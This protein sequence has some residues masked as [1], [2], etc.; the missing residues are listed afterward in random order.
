[1]IFWAK[2]SRDSD[3]P[4][5]MHPLICHMID[6]AMVAR[7]LWQD[8]IPP[9][10]RHRLA[11]DFRLDE[12][13]VGSWIAFWAGL[14]DIGKASPAFQSRNSSFVGQLE[15]E[16]FR[17]RTQHALVTPHGTM[18]ALVLQRLLSSTRFGLSRDLARRVA[19]IVGGHHG[20]F[21]R[22]SDLDRISIDASGE[23]S[24][25]DARVSLVEELATLLAIPSNAAPQYLDNATAMWLAGFVSVADWIG[26]STD[27]F[28]HHFVGRPWP[29]QAIDAT[30]YAA[31]A[32]AKTGRA[33]AALGWNAWPH[34]VEQRSFEALFPHIQQQ[35]SLQ[36]AIVDLAAG[37]R[38]D[39]AAQP[40]L[41]IIEAP[42]G[43]GKTE[44]AMYLADHFAANNGQLGCYFALPTQATS[45]QMF[46][47]VRQFLAGRY[48][49]DLV[50]LQLLHGHAS[51]SAE[52]EKLKQSGA[53]LF[54]PT[55]VAH[56]EDGGGTAGVAAA[57]W[58][59]YR[60]RGLLAPFGVGTVDQALM[61]ALQTKHMFVR[62][63]GLAGKTVIIDEVHA[64]DAYMSTL[65]E[66]LL[67]WLAA[68]GTSVILLSATLPRRRR[69]AL[70][71][72]YDKGRIPA[73][74]S[75]TESAA[76]PVA[77]QYV[78]YPRVTWSSSVGVTVTHVST[79]ARSRKTVEV[80]WI[81]GSLPAAANAHFALAE[82]LS[83]ALAHGGCA[84]VI[85]NTVNRAQQMY[86]ALEPYFLGGIGTDNPELD[87]VHARFP[88]EER[89][90]REKRIVRRFGK[91]QQEGDAVTTPQRNPH[92]PYRAV[93][94]ATQ[95]IEQSLDLD[96]DLLVT[97]IA[98]IDLVLQRSGRLHRHAE[99]EPR[100]AALQR[101]VLWVCNPVVE[102]DGVPKFDDGTAA[103]YDRHILLRSWL[104][105]RQ[106]A[107]LAVP[108]QVELLIEAVYDDS[109]QPDGVSEAV[110]RVW[111]ETWKDLKKTKQR[112]EYQ[113]ARVCVPSPSKHDDILEHPSLALEEDQP[114]IH[115]SLQA[116]T[117][118]SGPSVA[119]VLLNPSER[120]AAQNGSQP[121]P[122]HQVE[123]LL[124]KSLTISHR[125]LVPVLLEEPVPK[126]WQRSP[127]LRHHRALTLDAQGQALLG[128]YQVHLDP[129]IGVVITNMKNGN[130][131][132]AEL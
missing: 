2:L 21:P 39:E 34:G 120:D 62:L 76:I 91:E 7:A 87:I 77:E 38:N 124:H 127:L 8:V 108:D 86:R 79:S 17:C 131:A 54:Q 96:F 65:L 9:V 55:D 28:P 118:L 106:H 114:E 95:V 63:F 68:L 90:V 99:N 3:A 12:G 22:S 15:A 13:V 30:D 119:V 102:D 41:V 112:H 81:D 72:A 58:F 50:N 37:A 84:A 130:S 53:C 32:R 59:T 14:H 25:D 111:A 128:T 89:E 56:G 64:Y 94:I 20:I 123:R 97:D 19:A 101:P 110:R 18:S 113:A 107:A 88:F 80:V 24:W 10:Q 82:R 23:G 115:T 29:P 44:A 35:N 52:F 16:G 57:E 98:P 33:L 129:Q 47:R 60:K 46:E 40:S 4:Q 61:G 36:Q 51:L 66:R 93:L 43:E 125:G 49:H 31:C 5:T 126:R 83:R 116:L 78:A 69:E 73:K 67:E 85:C 117:R 105:L 109:Q 42:M 104:E 45:N 27:Y 11:A 1:M 121:L 103:V 132:D 92:R 100:P 70:S 26:S 71:I 74:P 75:S 48:P 122:L 6:V